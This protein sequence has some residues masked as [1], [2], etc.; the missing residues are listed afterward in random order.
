MARPFRESGCQC[1]RC[2]VDDEDANFDDGA[3]VET[4]LELL[5]D[6]MAMMGRVRAS[7]GETSSFLI[8]A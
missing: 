7:N 8:G 4:P 2:R 6:C 5:R 3:D 1:D